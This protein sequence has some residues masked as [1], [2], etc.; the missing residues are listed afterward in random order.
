M[1]TSICKNTKP[2]WDG[3]KSLLRSG[4]LWC[5]FSIIE[6]SLSQADLGF[7]RGCGTWGTCPPRKIFDFRPFEIAFCAALGWNSKIWTT[8]FIVFKR[9]H[10]LKAWLRF[11]PSRRGKKFS[12]S[13]CT[14]S[15]SRCSVDLRDWILTVC[16]RIL[17]YLLWYS[18]TQ[19]S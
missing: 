17:S 1:A 9:S 14:Y 7:S 2:M 4:A 3:S 10:N 15:F 6:S 16:H 8:N 12:A 11:A 5:S 18:T 13:Y 19:R